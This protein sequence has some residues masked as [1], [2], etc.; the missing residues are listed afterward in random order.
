MVLF[1]HENWTTANTPS[2]WILKLL[3]L[4]V[5][6]TG[7]EVLIQAYMN[8]YSRSIIL[9][10]GFEWI[11]I[12]IVFA[13]NR[14]MR[15]RFIP[16]MK[17]RH[18]FKSSEITPS[19]FLG[20]QIGPSIQNWKRSP[21]CK[22]ALLTFGLDDNRILLMCMRIWIFGEYARLCWKTSMSA[23]TGY[24]GFVSN[25]AKQT[26]VVYTRSDICKVSALLM[27]IT[28]KFFQAEP[29]KHYVMKK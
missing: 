26:W 23:I 6:V 15:R 1:H 7:C 12:S 24:E 13:K 17:Q 16:Y 8:N 18:T 21:H 27:Q 4:C 9:L 5:G 14:S 22:V 20:L 10:V 2:T 25:S 3:F 28:R 29:D 19:C 11:S